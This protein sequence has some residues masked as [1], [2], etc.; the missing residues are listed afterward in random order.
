MHL[1]A[2]SRGQLQTANVMRKD[3]PAALNKPENAGLLRL[4][5]SLQHRLRLAREEMFKRQF[6]SCGQFACDCASMQAY[7][8]VFAR[9]VLVPV[10]V[11]R[12]ACALC[13][14]ADPF[15]GP[16]PISGRDQ[17]KPRHFEEYLSHLR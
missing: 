4:Y 3:D 2:S 11:S 5:E 17:G 16:F 1:N 15:V 8:G 10:L 13:L 9:Y 7:P 6:V 14:R 12:C